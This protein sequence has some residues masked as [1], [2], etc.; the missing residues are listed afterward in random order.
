MEHVREWLRA[1]GDTLL[2]AEGIPWACQINLT[3]VKFPYR[4]PVKVD[5][6]SS[7]ALVIR[8]VCSYPTFDVEVVLGATV[9]KQTFERIEKLQQL[10]EK[11]ATLEVRLPIL[12]CHKLSMHP[13]RDMLLKMQPL[14]RTTFYLVGNLQAGEF[15]GA[16]VKVRAKLG[17]CTVEL[18]PIPSGGYALSTDVVLPSGFSWEGLFDP[19]KGYGDLLS[20]I[21]AHEA[22]GVALVSMPRWGAYVQRD[23]QL[24]AVL[25]EFLRN[26]KK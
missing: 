23:W 19:Y 13:F 2:S 3:Q 17:T 25:R 7:L 15:T 1:V 16:E 22:M 12:D 14:L 18:V 21:H 20:Y 26:F 9:S 6:G 8:E 24:Y 10:R 5:E 4:L 11:L